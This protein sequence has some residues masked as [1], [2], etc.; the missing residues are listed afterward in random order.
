IWPEAASFSDNG[1][2]PIPAGWK[3]IC[4]TSSDFNAS[5]CNRFV[6]E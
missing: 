2:G 3:G 5:N 6:G 4:M 1:M